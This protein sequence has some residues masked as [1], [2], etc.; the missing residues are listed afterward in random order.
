M[1]ITITKPIMILSKVARIFSFDFQPACYRSSR[2]GAASDNLWRVGW[3]NVR[4]AGNAIC[5]L[6]FER[7]FRSAMRPS[8]GRSSLLR[9]FGSERHLARF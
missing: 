1:V 7:R 8:N 9:N 4:L 2:G 3:I 5:A 6:H